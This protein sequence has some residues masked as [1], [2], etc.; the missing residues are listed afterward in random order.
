M[1]HSNAFTCCIKVCLSYVITRALPKYIIHTNKNPVI[2]LQS[3]VRFLN[4]ARMLC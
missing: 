3:L 2:F 1:Y 4:L